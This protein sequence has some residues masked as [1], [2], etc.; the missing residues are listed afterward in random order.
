MSLWENVRFL[1]LD[2]IVTSIKL[3]GGSCAEVRANTTPEGYPAMIFV[4]VGTPGNERVIEMGKVFKQT[5]E[6]ATNWKAEAQNPVLE[7]AG[8]DASKKP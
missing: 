5:L 6:A 1:T 4:L 7:W 3:S 2:E 8:E